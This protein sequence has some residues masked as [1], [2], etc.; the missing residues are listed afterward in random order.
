MLSCFNVVNMVT[1]TVNITYFVFNRCSK[2]IFSKVA[3]GYN[4]SFFCSIYIVDISQTLQGK[5]PFRCCKLFSNSG[6][7]DRVC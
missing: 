1:K 3:D 4:L 6:N 5:D 2:S 7:V